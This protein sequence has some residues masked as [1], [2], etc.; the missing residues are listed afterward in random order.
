[1][2]HL[3]ITIVS[4]GAKSN[5][6]KFALAKFL[7]DYS[8]TQN[9]KEED[10]EI[11]FYEIATKFLEY[12]W[13]QEC[14]YKFKQDFNKDK[15]P[16]VIRI[17][18]EH[19]GTEYIADSYEKYFKNRQELQK[20]L[21]LEIEK[22]CF[23]NVIPRFQPDEQNGFYQH[24][25]SRAKDGKAYKSSSEKKIILKHEAVKFFKEENEILSKILVLE[26]AKFLEKTNFTPR[27]ISKI[28]LM[29]DPKR[30]SLTKFRK[31]LMEMEEECFYCGTKLENTDVHIDH[32]IP[33]SY[34]YEDELWNL[35]QSCS[36]CNLIKSDSLPPKDCIEKIV[37]RN[38][39][40]AL[41]KWNSDITD[42]YEN[43]YKAGFQIVNVE[44]LQCNRA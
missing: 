36:K 44:N 6:Y 40:K 37:I 34:I 8:K 25:Y 43:C 13:F 12:Y 22:K 27:L 3:F 10:Y 11:S 23:D 41:S 14:K 1:M 16:V 28:E 9:L 30:N 26:W 31:I 18:Q 7:L 32:F 15:M 42:Y 17:I 35:V 4:K 33:W 20:T 24:F 39:Q 29:K 21:I 38:K 2:K 5:T 19:C